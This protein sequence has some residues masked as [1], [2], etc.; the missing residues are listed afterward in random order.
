MNRTDLITKGYFPEELLPPFTTED[1]AIVENQVIAS[2]DL[3]DPIAGNRKKVTTKITPFSIPKIKGYRRNLGIPHPL[4]YIRLADTIVNNWAAI[5]RHCRM[6]DISLSPIRIRPDAIRSLLKPSFKNT[7]REKIIRSTGYRFLLKIDIAKFYSSIYTHSIPWA[8]HTK[9]ISKIQRR[10]NTLFGNALDEDCRNMQDGQTIGLPIGPDSSRIISEIILTAI[11]VEIKS[12]VGYLTGVRVVDDYHLYFKNQGDLE[13]ARAVIHKALNDYELELNQN[14]ERLLDLPEIIESE[15]FSEIREFRF[16]N[17]WDYQRTDLITFFDTIVTFAKRF[18]EDLVLTYAM[19]KLRF[20]IFNVKNWN[21]LQALLLNSL[22][23]EPKILPYVAQN[24]VS[25]YE[26][27]YQINVNII[28]DAL[29]QFIDYHSPLSNDFEISWA[30]WITKSLRINLSQN[31]AALLSDNTNPIVILTVLD[32][33]SQGFIPVG[34]NK[35]AWQL[36]LTAENL[37]SEYWLVAY[38]ANLKGWLA[39]GPNIPDYIEADPFFKLL[40]DNQV[41]FYKSNRIQ[42]LS[43]VKIS[44]SQPYFAEDDDYEDDEQDSDSVYAAV[45]VVPPEP[46]DVAPPWND[47]DDLPF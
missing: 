31:T 45:A 37:Y 11:D 47:D 15:W 1:L 41:T 21:I 42:D 2:L 18:P 13:K 39:P 24:L 36:L 5:E 28:R 4:H 43:K 33:E 27:G 9:E 20:T 19:S 6:S 8:L 46:P 12:K 35:T 23:I 34:L 30:L 10:R 29:E 22:L 17:R 26:K 14:K 38:E 3:F 32:L 25:Y 16:R 40:K 7:V 44:T